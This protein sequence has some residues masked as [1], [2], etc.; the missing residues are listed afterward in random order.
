MNNHKCFYIAVVAL[1]ALL[2][3]SELRALE[4]DSFTYSHLGL[5]DGLYSQRIYSI[6]QTKD[7]ALWWSN[8]KGVE[9]YNGMNTRHYPLSSGE[10]YSSFAGHTVKLHVGA[11]N[12]LLYAFDNQGTIAVYDSIQD[13]FRPH[14][15]IGKM[16][17]GDV[18]LNDIL[19]TD[20]GLWLA[21]REGVYYLQGETLVPVVGHVFA[22]TIVETKHAL[23]FCTTNGVLYYHPSG[24]E[25]PKAG[26]KLRTLM[27]QNI[28]SAY[29]DAKYNKV[30][31]GG[32][33]Q[34][35]QILT[36]NDAGTNTDYELIG[37]AICNPVRS[38]C[39]Y[40]DETMLVGI[41]GLG[42][43]QVTRRPLPTGKYKVDLLFDANDGKAGVLHGNGVY[44]VMRDAW[45]NIVVGSYSGGIDI[46]RPVG[47]TPAIFQHIS[48]NMQ[49]LQNDHVN[50][51][52]Q[53]AD[54]T[55]VMGTDNGISLH[56]PFTRQ[57][58][59]TCPGAVVLSLCTTP[60]GT[61][62][63]STYGKGVFEISPNGSSHQL[64]TK[65]GGVLKDDHVYRL[66][67][68][69]DG[70]LWMGCLDGDLVQLTASG[71]QYYPI[72]NVQDIVQLPDGRVAV[73][74]AEGVHLISPQ[75][76]RIEE[77]DY[78]N[79]QPD[80]NRYAQTLFV[81]NGKELWIGTDG[82]GIYVY[83]LATSHA[84]QVTVERGLPSNV[85]CSLEKDVKG[86]IL[87]ATEEGLAFIHP[88]QPLKA[89][90]I[91]Y[92]YG[93]EREY[94]VRSV[95][96]MYNGHLLFGTTTGALIVNPD[97]VQEINY[98]A[99]LKL[100]GVSCSDDDDEDFKE[101]VHAM[102]HRK[103]LQLHYDQRTFSLYYE[104]INL[105]NQFDIVY[106]YKVGD[107]EWSVPTQEQ[108][109]HFIGMEAGTH[110][111]L[112]RCVSRTC[113]TVLDEVA[114][115]IVVAQP[116]WNSWWMW[117]VYLALILLAFYG[118]W[119]IYQLHTK[120]M[121]LVVSDP[122]L[123]PDSE[124]IIS[125]SHQEE[126]AGQQE[127]RQDTP[128]EA[129]SEES[130]DFIARVTKV[131]ADHLSDTEFNIDRLCR[132]MAMSRTLFYIK[133]KTFTGKSPQD[134]IRII[135]L[136]RAAVLLRNGRSVMDTATLTGFD[137]PK[138]FSTVFKKYFGLSPSKFC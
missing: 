48:G 24:Q 104:S 100:T 30:W 71:H 26:M 130:A 55:M 85:I 20:N 9:R 120:Y 28:Q 102:L 113:G 109:I 122:S 46:A 126:I 79:G 52:A 70:G 6:C 36:P 91:N 18:L 23:L 118:A 15:N 33:L 4:A 34:G 37:D 72:K 112:L 17:H 42:V 54:G 67:F 19:A 82:G 88:Q 8:K 74:T 63:A 90:C 61:M 49:S 84:I 138:Y 77:L 94:S 59:H 116:W 13:C 134:F 51:V 21:M 60:Q 81:N 108:S 87:V 1:C 66:F 45:G 106:Q 69:K 56:N 39:P 115:T 110:P 128:L 25:M 3:T 7:G 75:T 31:L 117:L 2:S 127:Q 5:A 103:R 40:D 124:K 86:R 136:E 76:G 137:N 65:Q 101:E 93:I 132:E 111:L 35:L 50:C 57:W 14:A 119:R 11:K 29:Y 96:N 99:Q 22:N 114:L 80:V 12:S 78:S 27:T 68:D 44:A 62:L 125:D 43:Y 16:L 97:N 41:D 105:R 53:F 131:V 64:Y 107:G 58:V 95:F 10:V 83:D 47:S 129:S 135:R 73:G 92:C 133:L 121:R 89:F 123:N 38:I 32:F 98:T